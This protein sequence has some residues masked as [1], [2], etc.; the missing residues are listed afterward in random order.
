MAELPSSLDFA[1]VMEAGQT[2]SHKV[3]ARH[4]Q[5]RWTNE[6][7]VMASAL[8]NLAG[9]DCV[10]DL[11]MLEGDEGPVGSQEKLGIAAGPAWENGS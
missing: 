10:E 1:Q 7:I 6:R 3:K 9:G 4:G 2:V 5:Q 11:V 8:L